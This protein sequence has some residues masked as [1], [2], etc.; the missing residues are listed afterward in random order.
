MRILRRE[1][2]ALGVAGLEGG[3]RLGLSHAAR[4]QRERVLRVILRVILRREL[5]AL[6]VAGLE[7]GA[8]LGL[9]HAR[10]VVARRELKVGAFPALILFLALAPA[11]G[12]AGLKHL[13]HVVVRRRG[14]E[15]EVGGR[16]RAVVGCGRLAARRELP[17]SDVAGLERGALHGL[18]VVRRELEVVVV[19]RRL[20]GGGGHGPSV[21]VAGL[22]RRAHCGLVLVGVRRRELEL[23]RVDVGVDVDALRGHG[24]AVGVAGL[25][26]GA[27]LAAI[28][29]A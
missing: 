20:V 10:L 6:G 7:G 25:E 18:L 24:P 21:L 12:E 1:L 15:A 22:E 14:G 4:R 29:I 26:R 16:Q 8:R 23:G 2:P 11:L 17:P 19:R 9:G 13:A 3:A 28:W 5:P 27:D